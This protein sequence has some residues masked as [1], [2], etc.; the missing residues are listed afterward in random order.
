MLGT[1][2]AAQFALLHAQRARRFGAAA[3]LAPGA[4]VRM[5]KA[6]SVSLR[7]GPVTLLRLGREAA[8]A[9]AAW[10]TATVRVPRRRLGC[11]PW[12]AGCPGVALLPSVRL[13]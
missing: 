2:R 9:A 7:G 4:E 10:L 5:P 6:G 8:P 1:R 11:L 12:F 13:G 3:S